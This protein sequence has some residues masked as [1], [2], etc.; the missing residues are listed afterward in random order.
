MEPPDS[1]Y[2]I[3]SPSGLGQAGRICNGPEWQLPLPAQN[4]HSFCLWLIPTPEPIYHWAS[5]C[6]ALG[7]PTPTPTQHTPS[8]SPAALPPQLLPCPPH[9]LPLRQASQSP[10]EALPCPLPLVPLPV[11]FSIT[12]VPSWPC[13]IPLPQGPS[14]VVRTPQ[15]WDLALPH[16]TRRKAAIAE[17]AGSGKPPFIVLCL[18]SGLE[19]SSLGQ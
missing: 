14:M 1:K 6:W 2:M 7:S 4:E 19:G 13:L 12:L 18:P 11:P 16:C 5:C 8:F 10:Q 15:L 3:N 9:A 17:A